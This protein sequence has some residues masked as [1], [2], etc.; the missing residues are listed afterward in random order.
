MH[1]RVRNAHEA[2]GDT[3]GGSAIDIALSREA[4]PGLHRH[5][6]IRECHNGS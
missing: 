4:I 2:Y 3:S 1:G 5:R 6:G